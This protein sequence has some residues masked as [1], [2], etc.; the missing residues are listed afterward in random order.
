MKY[1]YYLVSFTV[2]DEKNLLRLQNAWANQ[3][4]TSDGVIGRSQEDTEAITSDMLGGEI[5]LLRVDKEGN[6][7]ILKSLQ[8]RTPMGMCISDDGS[9]LFVNCDHWLYEY[10]AGNLQKVHNNKLFNCNHGIFFTHRKTIL[11]AATGV[12]A[13][14]EID[15]ED[16]EKLLWHWYAPQN[17][18]PISKNGEIREI[19]YTQKL[20]EIE[21]ST[22][23]HT[24]P[25]L[26]NQYKKMNLIGY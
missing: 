5:L 21:F 10:R 6:S 23:K 26:K 8:A 13:I 3:R 17:G 15:P 14:L 19:D 16:T 25:V 1:D 7:T 4:N 11:I 12:D 24:N 2:T 20:Q 9:Q 22:P 18:F